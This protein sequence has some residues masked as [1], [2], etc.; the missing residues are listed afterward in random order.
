MTSRKQ[1]VAQSGSGTSQTPMMDTPVVHEMYPTNHLFVL[2]PTNPF[3]KLCVRISTS[4][5]FDMFILLAIVVNCIMMAIDA[6][7]PGND[8]SQM[9]DNIASLE[10]YLLGIFIAESFFKIVSQGFLLHPD[11]Y[12]RSGWNILDF[13][14]VVTGILG[15]PEVGLA[16]QAGPMKV[17]KAARVL[18][19]LKLVSGIPSLQVVMSAILKSMAS[20][21]QICLLI[22]FVIV[23]YGIVF[24]SLLVG[25]FHYTCF[26]QNTT[27]IYEEGYLCGSRPCPAG[28]NLE[29]REF[30][31]GPNFG[32]T[33]YDNILIA[34][35]TVFVCITCEGWTDTMYWSFDVS[36]ADGLYMWL[37]YYTLNVIGSQFML[38]LVC[39]VL[40]GEFSKEK[41]R[42]ENRTAFLKER[43]EEAAAENY[44]DWVTAGQLEKA[45][46]DEERLRIAA[47]AAAAEEEGEDEG[48]EAPPQ[49]GCFQ[50]IKMRNSIIRAKLKV[51]ML[52]AFMYWFV[53]FLVF[54]NSV[55]GAIQHYRQPQW[56]SDIISISDNLFLAF[57]FSEMCLKLYSL[58]PS[59]YFASKFNK[60]DFV[61]VISGLVNMALSKTKGINLGIPVLRQLRLMRLFK[62]TSYWGAMKNLV[63]SILDSMAS[64]LSLLVLLFLFLMIFAL[65][66]MQ[67]F[68]GTFRGNGY[69]QSRTNF[70]DFF[71]AMLAVFQ[72]ITGEDWNFVMYEGVVALGGPRSPKG[73][74][75]SLYFV[76]VT[77]LGNYVLLNV[78]LAIAVDNL[79]MSD[80]EEGAVAE[81]EAAREEHM[82][83]VR[84]KYAPPG[85]KAG[86]E[87]ARSAESIEP[88]TDDEEGAVIIGEFDTVPTEGGTLQPGEGFLENLKNPGR[89]T[90]NIHQSEGAE[91]LQENTLFICFPSNPIR[92]VIHLIVSSA[93]FDNTILALILISSGLLA[94]EDATDP[95]ASVN[96]ILKYCDYVFTSIFALEVV[97]KIINYGFVLHAGSYCRDTWNCA[98]MFVVLCAITSLILSMNPNASA[99]V[100]QIVKILRILRVLRPLKSIN[101]LPK[102]K[103][104]FQCMIFSLKNVFNILIITLQFLFIFSV[105]GV[106]LFSGK[107]FY[108]SDE[109]KEFEDECQGYFITF[110]E[111]NYNRPKEVAREWAVMDFNFNNVFNAMISLFTSSTG[112]GWPAVMQSGIDSQD[113]D[114]GPILNSKIWISIYFIVFVIIFS[115]FFI[116]VFVGMIIL[117]FQEQGAAEAGGELDRNAKNS[118]QFA[119]TSKPI[120]RFMPEDVKSWQYKAWAL[121]ESTP[122]EL[123]IMSLISLNTIVLMCEFHDQPKAYED[124]L[125]QINDVFT[126]VFLGEFS[127]KMF[128]LGC[129][130][131]KDGW[132]NFDM[133]IVAGSLMDFAIK[134]LLPPGTIDFDPSIFRLFRAARLVKLLRR[135]RSLRILLWTFLQSF[136][137]LP[138][139]GM[140]IFLLFFVYG[141]VGVQI[142][143]LISIDNPDDPW[144]QINRNNHFRSYF[145]STQVLF[146]VATGENW[147][148][149]MLACT[150]PALCDTSL[151]AVEATMKTCGTNVAY[152]YF[153]SFVF[154]CSFLMLNLFIAVIMDNFAFLTEDSS[155]LGP[156]HL[157][158][159][160]TVWSDF[161][162]RASGRIK[163]TEVCE[164]LRQMLPPV[165]LGLKCPRIVAYKRLVQM[166][167]TLFKD[168]S[169]DYTATFFALVRTGLK[170]YTENANIKSNDQA[171]RKMLK[172][173]WPNISKR[174]LDLVIPRTPRNA[175]HMTVG[176]IYSAKLIWENYKNMKKMGQRRKSIYPD[177]GTLNSSRENTTE[178]RSSLFPS[179]ANAPPK[180]QSIPASIPASIPPS[181]PASIPASDSGPP[182]TPS[183]K[184]LSPRK[185]NITTSEPNNTAR[186][187]IQVALAIRSGKDPYQLYGLE[188][189]TEDKDEWC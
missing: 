64:I 154:F 185:D 39:G 96:N 120:E 172:E 153:I 159:F 99:T 15:M 124:I 80:E 139:V 29:C 121:I 30:W 89:M 105:M 136:K 48:V 55:S 128:A 189:S 113:A 52:S 132:N 20:L 131:F 106:Q 138:Y 174:T 75:A 32:I 63:K 123:L 78:F 179:S 118:L 3:R 167:M 137:A 42:V 79:T 25:K 115:F 161:D 66:G 94:L 157:D 142:F 156:H 36:D 14:V 81:E 87:T 90:G 44:E 117:T 92:K 8:K 62:Y 45:K 165:G 177:I 4:K 146:R 59:L 18:R 49:I 133:L 147:P 95:N 33:S 103:A 71:N 41:E 2:T 56:I 13:T 141:I 91:M 37:F 77:V 155:I 50:K 69:P 130:Y 160:V 73:L 183:T 82:Q 151:P 35:L 102:L 68:G 186:G 125:G 9:N 85:S 162:P 22:G 143:S 101:K 150:S 178:K 7:L 51:V 61:V 164:L 38:N 26:Y 175:E 188:G 6:P 126:F 107:L 110:D 127:V 100:K 57:F 53:I 11:S 93:Y 168:G 43:A 134:K 84:E 163:H 12:L 140:L 149:I 16:E 46:E 54:C 182:P 70:D 176:K 171:L 97:L 169:V 144:N 112:E 10:I 58:G 111:Y 76:G 116:N 119:M 31:D 166:N 83:E 67:V 5:A 19:P 86:D 180:R 104:V 109:S 173:T 122:W 170:I 114:Q 152:L 72:I 65:L 60:F 98:D 187:N 21:L 1:S 40:S 184:L 28:K 74:A 158:E 34:C 145:S 17:I 88:A 108:C 23:I 148:N 135:S 47:E 181:I 24:L 27:I 129:N